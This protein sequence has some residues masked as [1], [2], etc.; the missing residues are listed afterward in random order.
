MKLA[1]T[2]ASG[3]SGGALVTY[4]RTGGNEVLR[5][6]RRAPK[7]ND[8]ARW[9]PESGAIEEAALEGVDAVVHLAGA[10]IAGG[11][12]SEARKALLCSSRVGPTRR[13]AETLARRKRKPRVLVSA[14]ALGYYGHRGDTWLTERDAPADDF[15]GRLSVEWEAATAPAREAGIR[16]VNPRLGIVLSPAGGAL[17]KMLP[18]FK[19]GLGGVVG[20][21]TQYMS[22]IA[23]DDLVAVIQ[24]LLDRSDLAGPVNAVAPSPVTNAELTKTLGRVLG[25]PTLVPVPAFA[26]RLALGEMAETLLASTRLRPQRLL[27]TGFRFRF[28]ELEGALRHVLGTARG[29]RA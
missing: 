18:P 16:V 10:N 25:R 5:L 15:L 7:A 27:D 2:G 24:H 23:L 4:M 8:E 19:A 9:D 14:S 17:A 6:V 13:L 28:P 1:G 3:L 29:R 21:G 20:P 11:R 26:L 12:W 22:W